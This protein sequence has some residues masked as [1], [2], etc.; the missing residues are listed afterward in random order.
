MC[1]NKYEGET[2]FLIGI[3]GMKDTGPLSIHQNIVELNAH[4]STM[5]PI[6]DMDILVLHG[7]LTSA[8]CLPSEVGRFVY[9]VVQDPDDREAGCI[10]EMDR[11]DSDELSEFVTEIINGEDASQYY[12]DLDIDNVFIFY[13]YELNVSYFMR[14]DEIDDEAL[15]ECQIVGEYVKD[16][17]NAYNKGN[18]DVTE[19]ETHVSDAYKSLYESFLRKY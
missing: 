16:M 1:L 5:S 13:G 8:K 10:Y 3:D 11:L 17:E 4:L 7:V 18:D 6:S 12:K 14:N 19:D 15:E 2:I 9:V